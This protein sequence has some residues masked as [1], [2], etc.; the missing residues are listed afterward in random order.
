MAEQEQSS[1]Q[2]VP[3]LEYYTPPKLRRWVSVR[4]TRVVVLVMAWALL[5]V[6]FAEMVWLGGVGPKV[7]TVVAVKPVGIADP[8]AA[9]RITEKISG[10]EYSD[11]VF[12]RVLGYVSGF[13][14][15]LLDGQMSTGRS[16]QAIAEGL[17]IEDVRKD[18]YN[19]VVW[20]KLPT[21]WLAAGPGSIVY[22]PDQGRWHT[23]TWWRS[24]RGRQPDFGFQEVRTRIIYEVA[25]GM[26]GDTD[27]GG[28]VWGTSRWGAMQY[29]RWQASMAMRLALLG[30]GVLG[31]LVAV[32]SLRVRT[33]GGSRWPLGCRLAW[34]LLAAGLFCHAGWAIVPIDEAFR[35]W[36]KPVVPQFRVLGFLLAPVVAGL[37]LS[38]AL[39]AHRW[40]QRDAT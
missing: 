26:E 22:W 16:E 35:I 20:S 2:H 40:R 31:V 8:K 25:E 6:L 36:S 38:G 24:E 34:S 10:G 5:C 4:Q 28:T 9:I 14:M 15:T 21:G 17:S 27:S 29:V 19:E 30:T 1:R 33:D 18:P 23:E 39:A 3:V 7:P 32:A 11:E 37:L 12:R 13:G